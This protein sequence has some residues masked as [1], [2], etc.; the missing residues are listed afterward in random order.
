MH[1]I[2]ALT[3]VLVAAGC[4]GQLG[5]GDGA[6]DEAA[7][8]GG[9]KADL[10]GNAA[11]TV[12]GIYQLA[13]D[14]AGAGDVVYL[15][16]RADGS[17]AWTRC[18]D[19]DCAAP[20]VEDGTYQLTTSSS[21][22]KYIAFY[23]I[24]PRGDTQV[25]FNSMYAYARTASALRLRKTRTSRWM[26]L[27]A[28]AEPDLC[29][30]SGGT[31]SGSCSCGAGWPTAYSPGAGGC[32]LSPSAGETACD[33]SQ[34]TYS[35]DEANAAGTFCDCGYARHLTDAGCVDNNF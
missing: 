22:R 28:A 32:W 15:W 5:S 33:D 23:Q 6:A 34:G 10:A 17:F 12:A 19:A 27:A 35:D 4:G 20:V 8:A 26:T 3:F 7:L 21:G 31:W 16:L 9:G 2:L 13:G 25:H 1:K 24:G 29:A 14:P 11:A 18:Y 30:A